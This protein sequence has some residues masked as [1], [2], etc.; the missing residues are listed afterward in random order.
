MVIAISKYDHLKIT[1]NIFLA[2]LAIAD[3]SVGILAMPPNALQILSGK[4]YLKAFM[5]RFWFSC[6]VLF[7]TASI[8][9]LCCVSIDRYL[10][11]S[12]KYAF[13]YRSE[14]PT[15]SW[16]VRFM[17][18]A[19][20]II[21]AL[22]SFVPI[23]TNLYTTKEQ[24][25]SIDNLDNVNGQCFFIVNSKYRII[26]SLVSFWIPGLTMIIFYTLVMK[27]A[28][29]LETHE[30]KI[31]RS[32]Y[33][34][35]LSNNRLGNNQDNDEKKINNSRIARDSVVKNWKREYKVLFFYILLII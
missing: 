16:R 2:S 25:Y 18:A 13:N 35:S 8:M 26:S 33:G 14:H 17:I 4:W 30:F 15:K 20:W 24:V 3:C 23:F 6:D 10:S 32:I 19:V 29:H 12:D 1:N 7:S 5:C 11:I 31:N 21:S 9:H 22:L 28:Y 27:K 34:L